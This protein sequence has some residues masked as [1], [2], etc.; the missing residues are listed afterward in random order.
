MANTTP[1]Q[2]NAKGFQYYRYDP[3]MAAAI[4][5]VVMFFITT[6]IHSYQFV[7]TRTWIMIPLLVG[8]FCT[9]SLCKIHDIEADSRCS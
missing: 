9:Q 4:I 5:F 3:S 8:G 7:R 2:P 1:D 6:M